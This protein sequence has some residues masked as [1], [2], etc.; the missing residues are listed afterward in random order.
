MIRKAQMKNVQILSVCIG[1][2]YLWF[3]FLKFFPGTSPAEG[4][5]KNTIHMLTMG[6]IPDQVSYLMLAVWETGLGILFLL[7]YRRKWVIYLAL[8]H[9]VCTFT[10]LIFFPEV[11]FQSATP[12]LT[13]TGQYIIKNLVI[14][15]ALITVY[16]ADAMP[17]QETGAKGSPAA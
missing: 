8:A 5:A 12:A 7:T 11:S 4:L 16:P 3:G 6:F 9:M 17:K 13:L 2:V 15:A 10:P 1:I 14:I